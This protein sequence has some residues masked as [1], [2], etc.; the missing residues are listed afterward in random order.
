MEVSSN[1]KVTSWTNQT[2]NGNLN[3]IEKR[4]NTYS[5]K[6]FHNIWLFE[7]QTHFLRVCLVAVSWNK[8][9][10]IFGHLKRLAISRIRLDD[11]YGAVI[12]HFQTN[13][14]NF[15]Q[16]GKKWVRRL[17]LEAAIIT[18]TQLGQ[19]WRLRGSVLAYGDGGPRF[20][21][22]HRLKIFPISVFT[23]IFQLQSPQRLPLGVRI[24]FSYCLYL[25]LYSLTSSF[26][27]CPLECF[28]KPHKFNKWS[29]FSVSLHN[30]SYLFWDPSIRAKLV[31]LVFGGARKKITMSQ[32]VNE[33]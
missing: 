29:L 20:E 10:F 13:L 19:R 14:P 32:L 2:K 3:I 17:C 31:L 15:S 12:S 18:L 28:C 5:L 11:K 24:L 33:S 1:L 26:L 30:H 9:I 23:Q 6:T 27:L 16:G 8:L 22:Q 7:S 25:F 21:S 4:Y